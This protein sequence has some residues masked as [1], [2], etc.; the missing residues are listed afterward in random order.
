MRFSRILIAL[1]L[2]FAFWPA[3]H[4]MP[5]LPEQLAS[6]FDAAGRVDGWLAKG[7][8]FA[9]NLVFVVGMALL[10]LGLTA[11]LARV[12]NEWISLPHKDYCLSSWLGWWWCSANGTPGRRRE[13]MNCDR[14]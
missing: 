13:L 3:A 2:L 4:Y 1:F 7:D 5:L 14:C 9:L 10:F 8:F 6:H 12:P 11:W